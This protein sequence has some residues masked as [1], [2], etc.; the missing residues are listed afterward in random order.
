MNGKICKHCGHTNLAENNYCASCGAPFEDKVPDA[1]RRTDTVSKK[2]LAVM[3]LLITVVVNVCMALLL[4][5]LVPGKETPARACSH[6]WDDA[7]CATLRTCIACGETDGAYGEHKWLPADCVT[8]ERCSVC[9]AVRGTA[10]GHVWTAATYS[11]PETCEVCK[12]TSGASLKD[13]LTDVLRQNIPF[14]TYS[15]SQTEKVYGYED[16][17]L[18]QKSEKRYFVPAIDELV[19]MDIS[20]DG[21]AVQVRYPGKSAASGYRAL[22]FP[23]EEIIPLA[24]IQIGTVETTEKITTYKLAQGTSSVENYG[25]I[26]SNS[27]YTVLGVHDSGCTVVLY[28]I[29]EEDINGCAVSIRIALIQP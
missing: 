7:D 22:W 16:A 11:E 25:T 26:V 27:E 5:S 13:Q 2:K 17:A 1:K 20:E 15:T 23:I 10:Q 18:T 8:P 9:E 21:S 3:A 29:A 28:H 6:V 4:N 24:Q 19:I 12:T 14:T